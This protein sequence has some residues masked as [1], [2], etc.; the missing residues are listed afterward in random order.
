MDLKLDL[1]GVLLGLDDVAI[2]IFGVPITTRR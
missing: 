1:T 2:L